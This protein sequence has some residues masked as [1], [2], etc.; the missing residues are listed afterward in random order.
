M[1]E[2]D[3]ESHSRVISSPSAALAGRHA[4]AYL[5]GR[6]PGLPSPIVIM[7]QPLHPASPVSDNSPTAG[8]M[9]AVLLFAGAGIGGLVAT[10]ALALWFHYG[11]QMFFETIKTGFAACF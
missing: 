11:T 5:K 9:P 6:E 2:H 7:A 10:G 1:P 4:S 8:R 3:G